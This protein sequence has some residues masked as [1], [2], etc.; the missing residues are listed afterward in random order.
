MCEKHALAQIWPTSLYAAPPT[1]WSIRMASI[2]KHGN[3]YQCCIRSK[4]FPV[5]SKVFPNK[6][7]AVQWSKVVESEMV[8]GVFIDR[9]E[10]EQ[11]TRGEALARYLTERT[12]QKRGAKQERRRIH[13][14]IA[15]PW[16]AT[17]L[18]ALLWRR[19]RFEPHADRRLGH[20]KRAAR[21]VRLE[22]RRPPTGSPQIWRMAQIGIGANSLGCRL[23]EVARKR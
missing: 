3:G 14:L 12:P 20:G 22:F 1:K 7:Q 4:G 6:A 15:L 18:A 16:A 2:R 9:S 10:A 21:S 23:R 17:S 5:Q 19:C 8:R 13:T 11:T